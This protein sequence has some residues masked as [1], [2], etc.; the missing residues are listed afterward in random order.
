MVFRKHQ[1]FFCCLVCCCF[2]PLQRLTDKATCTWQAQPHGKIRDFSRLLKTTLKQISHSQVKNGF[3]PT[4][5]IYIP[6]NLKFC[7]VFLEKIVS[8]IMLHAE[9]YDD[10]AT[11]SKAAFQEPS[12][13]YL[14]Q[15]RLAW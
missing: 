4:E 15:A 8:E 9:Q 6:G 11:S 12:F 7:S 1:S 10:W 2:F 3:L 13:G 5:Y 14:L